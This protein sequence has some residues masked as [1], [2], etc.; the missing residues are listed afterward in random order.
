[1]LDNGYAGLFCKW[2]IFNAFSTIILKRVNYGLLK[3]VYFRDTRFS[4][5]NIEESFFKF[6]KTLSG[7][8]KIE[9]EDVN[10]LKLQY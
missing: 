7:M 1:M 6:R 2:C 3:S 8:L 5:V 9:I 10:L 4:R